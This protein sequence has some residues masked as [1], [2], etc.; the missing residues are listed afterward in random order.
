MPDTS[1][2]ATLT[3]VVVAAA[4]LGCDEGPTGPSGLDDRDGDDF[5]SGDLPTGTGDD[6]DSGFND[7]DGCIAFEWGRVV[8]GYSCGDDYYFHFENLCGVRVW[9]EWEENDHGQSAAEVDR[10]VAT[11]GASKAWYAPADGSMT[12]SILCPGDR[13]DGAIGP[14]ITYCYRDPRADGCETW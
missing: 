12:N 4:V 2:R 13:G 9:L 8:E 5:F 1:Q 6:R 11:R 14:Y 3:C 7:V 10:R